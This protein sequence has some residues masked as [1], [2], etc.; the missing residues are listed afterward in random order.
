MFNLD[1]FLN[2]REFE[3]NEL[4]LIV[5]GRGSNGTTYTNVE[6]AIKKTTQLPE[7]EIQDQFSCYRL[8]QP[9]RW[10]IRGCTE[11]M[12]N[13]LNNKI[14]NM[15]IKSDGP[16]LVFRFQR[17]AEE[18]TKLRLLW[19]PPS[20]HLD[21]V[22]RLAESVFGPEVKVER[23]NERRDLSRIDITM[24]IRDQGEI[25]YYIPYKKTTEFG[26]TEEALIMISVK[27]RK[28]RCYHCHSLDHWPNMCRNKMEQRT[29]RTL[30]RRIAPAASGLVPGVSYAKIAKEK[31]TAPTVQPTAPPPQPIQKKTPESTP[32]KTSGKQGKD[33]SPISPPP[34]EKKET[35]VTVAPVIIP[36][37]RASPKKDKKDHT[38][39]QKEER[40]YAKEEVEKSIGSAKKKAIERKDPMMAGTFTETSNKR[41]ARESPEKEEKN[42]AKTRKDE[43]R[44]RSRSKSR[45]TEETTPQ[46]EETN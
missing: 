14:T 25:P 38:K 4:V 35:E 30:G 3:D 43:T 45:R 2:K 19:V 41:K 17:K 8:E 29:E 27:G 26:K 13:K 7:G 39:D 21:A 10:Y 11:N 37:T 46:E 42:E 31:K 12:I 20:L 23:P 44:A 5:E 22:R 18:V 24:P 28:Q 6:D 36:V 16:E 40:K 34:R 33:D 32:K 1:D 9:N 15:K